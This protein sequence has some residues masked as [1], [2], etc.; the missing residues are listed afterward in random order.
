MPSRMAAKK[1]RKAKHTGDSRGQS[2][3]QDWPPSAFPLPNSK[4]RDFDR[5]KAASPDPMQNPMQLSNGQMFDSSAE[6]Q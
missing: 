4:S 2:I 5:S 3:E 1:E 6:Q